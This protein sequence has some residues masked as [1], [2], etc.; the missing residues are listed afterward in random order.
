MAASPVTTATSSG[1][2]VLA[3]RSCISAEVRGVSSDGLIRARLP[4]ARTLAR[5]AK[6]RKT[7]K[8]HGAMIPTTPLG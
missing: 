5:G 1:A 2:N 8:F 4:A 7:G 6:T 3:M